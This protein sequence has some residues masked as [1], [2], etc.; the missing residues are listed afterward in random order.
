MLCNLTIDFT[1]YEEGTVVY[2]VL[3]SFALTYSISLPKVKKVTVNSLIITPLW[4]DV[5]F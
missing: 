3:T 1:K 2:K 5:P 4:I